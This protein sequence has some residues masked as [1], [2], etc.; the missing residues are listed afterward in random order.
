MCQPDTA[1]YT[2]QYDPED[3]PTPRLKSGAQRTCMKW[4][5]FHEWATSRA[6]GYHPR[7][8]VPENYLKELKQRMGVDGS[9]EIAVDA[10]Y[11]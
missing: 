4:D 3:H 1:L 11:V 9:E 2:F 8:K 6:P 10:P 7:V 5:P